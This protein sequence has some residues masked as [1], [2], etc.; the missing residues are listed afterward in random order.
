M[1]FASTA[2]SGQPQR[3]PRAANILRNSDRV[4]TFGINWFLNAWGRIQMNYIHETIED[5]ERA[6]IQ[7]QT[8]FATFVTR[9]QFVL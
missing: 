8:R 1:R 5:P 9:L 6:P 4:W 7:G 3:N 2:T